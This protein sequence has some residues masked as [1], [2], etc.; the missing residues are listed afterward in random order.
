MWHLTDQMFNMLF[1]PKLFRRQRMV[2]NKVIY[3]MYDNKY[4]QGLTDNSGETYVWGDNLVDQT[5][6]YF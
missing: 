6:S 1:E 5:W 4:V 2:R 3:N